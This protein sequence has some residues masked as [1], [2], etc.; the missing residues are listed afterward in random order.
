M[1]ALES[2]G[3]SAPLTVRGNVQGA[4]ELLGPVQSVLGT[5]A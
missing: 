1:M 2:S 4:G 5:A 3:L